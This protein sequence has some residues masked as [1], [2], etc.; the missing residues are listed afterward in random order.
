MDFKN[1]QSVRILACIP[2]YN[3]AKTIGNGVRK[4]SDYAEEIKYMVMDPRTIHMISQRLQERM[5]LFGAH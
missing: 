2:A 5:M 4:S 1:Q 3:E